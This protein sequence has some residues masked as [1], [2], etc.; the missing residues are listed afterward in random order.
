[1]SVADT[2]GAFAWCVLVAFVRTVSVSASTA[3][4][5]RSRLPACDS[6]RLARSVFPLAISALAVTIVSADVLMPDTIDARR[7][8]ISLRGTCEKL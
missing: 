6:V 8:R 5:V 7:V 2:T 1:M 4:V 3:R